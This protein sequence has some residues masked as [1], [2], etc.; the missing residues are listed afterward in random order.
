LLQVISGAR[1]ELREG[2][3]LSDYPARRGTRC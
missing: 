1:T 2:R 3:A